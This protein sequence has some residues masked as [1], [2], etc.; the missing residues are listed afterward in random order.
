MRNQISMRSCF[1]EEIH[2]TWHAH[3]LNLILQVK[4]PFDLYHYLAA[5]GHNSTG[6]IS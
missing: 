3:V 1:K 5:I 4:Q 2:L 6:G